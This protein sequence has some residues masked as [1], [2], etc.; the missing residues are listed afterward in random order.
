LIVSDRRY[1]TTAELARALAV[2][3]TTL[4]RWRRQGMITPELVTAG[5]QARWVE[6][7]VRAQLRELNEK[8]RQEDDRR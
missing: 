5:G 8:S 1:M 4:Q 7:D 6:E 2:S 3:A